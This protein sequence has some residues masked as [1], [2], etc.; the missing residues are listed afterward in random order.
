MHCVILYY[1]LA[2]GTWCHGVYIYY[3][4]ICYDF[5]SGVCEHSITPAGVG[6]SE[7]LRVAASEAPEG[8]REGGGEGGS[9]GIERKERRNEGET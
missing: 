1:N 5:P 2:Y 3:F 9:G 4:T 7:V 8:K 6:F